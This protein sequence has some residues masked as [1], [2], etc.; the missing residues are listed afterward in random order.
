MN[1]QLIG[2]FS[3]FFAVGASGVAVNMGFLILMTEGLGTPY[4][5][6][7]LVAIEFSILS[8]F[9][10]NNAWTWSDRHTGS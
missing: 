6:S 7:S 4:A 2:R 8:N 3:R 1:S 9:T 10:L 5:I